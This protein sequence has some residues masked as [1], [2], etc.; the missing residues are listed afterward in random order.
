MSLTSE[1]TTTSSKE[2][3]DEGFEPLCISTSSYPASVLNSALLHSPSLHISMEVVEVYPTNCISIHAYFESLS[4]PPMFS[5]G[6]LLGKSNFKVWR[7]SIEPALLK[8]PYSSKLILGEWDEPKVQASASQTEAELDQ[9]RKDWQFANTATCRFIRAT[10]ALNVTP[11]VR[12][13]STAKALY[14]NL[15][16]LYGGE[17][18]IDTQGG[19]PV[20]SNAKTGNPQTNRASL[21]AALESDKPLGDVTSLASMLQA[22]SGFASSNSS[23]TS[24]LLKSP[25]SSIVATG[26]KRPDSQTL[27]VKYLQELA[28]QRPQPP[29]PRIHIYE[30]TRISPDASLETIHEEPHPGRRVS[31]SRGADSAKK[32]MSVSPVTSSDVSDDDDIVSGLPR[33]DHSNRDLD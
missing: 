6:Q 12:Q 16:W 1:T 2:A 28:A 14:L 22:P 24:L 23:T 29:P 15:I 11:F 7:A 8:N 5:I 26:S 27:P 30:R 21:L 13:H 17:A 25:T 9:A 33:R 31:L 20:P 18:G 4:F 32:S 3:N 10:L 19:P